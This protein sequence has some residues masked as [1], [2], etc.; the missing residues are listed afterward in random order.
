MDDKQLRYFLQRYR[1]ERRKTL[2][3]L[4]MYYFTTISLLISLFYFPVFWLSILISISISFFF[5]PIQKK[6]RALF[7]VSCCIR[8]HEIELGDRR[9]KTIDSKIRKIFQPN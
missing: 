1:T 9:K 4:L 7:L 3:I 5:E 2:V 8:I 6:R